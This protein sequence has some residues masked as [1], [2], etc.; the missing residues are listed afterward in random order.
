MEQQ[1]IKIEQLRGFCEQTL[2]SV[3]SQ[4]VTAY[5]IASFVNAAEQWD[6]KWVDEDML[7]YWVVK[8]L[9]DGMKSSSVKKYIGQIHTIYRRHNQEGR[10]DPF[11]SLSSIVDKSLEVKSEEAIKN[12][13]I[14]KRIF[15]IGENG[16]DGQAM[17]IFLYLLYDITASVNDVIDLRFE[18]WDS[19]C[20]QIEDIINA[21]PKKYGRKYVFNLNQGRLQNTPIATKLIREMAQ[22]LKAAG[23]GFENGFSRDSITAMWI[24]AAIDAGVDLRD[25]RA[26]VS[27]IPVQFSALTLLGDRELS[28]KTIS[29]TI[30]KVAN[31]INDNASRWFVMK[32]RSKVSVDDVKKRI[33]T[34]LPDLMKS[35]MLFYPT[36]TV[37][38]KEGKNNIKE[39]VPLLPEL[40]FFKTK[41]HKVKSMFNAIGDLAWCFKVSNSPDS[42]YSV[43][44]NRDMVNFQQCVGQFSSDIRMELVDT[45][46]IYAKGR[47]VKIVGG[48]MAGY[49]GEIL[50]VE[51]EPE[52]KILSLKITNAQRAQWKVKVEDI[53]IEPIETE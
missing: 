42:E 17:A 48:I 10:I 25:I 33:A 16:K 39:D 21:Q 2:E 24:V 19:S 53:F 4:S 41:R 32:L 35:L 28:E 9:I 45:D 7:R 13:A 51:D 40:L 27:N 8:M 49:E 18:E 26:M 3:E 34:A 52:T 37:V 46:R 14:T 23:M 29:D 22:G 44:S 6:G 11:M 31:R 30:C 20:Q 43:I 38:R 12:L 36:R 50:D 1:P 5:A 15:S 47:M